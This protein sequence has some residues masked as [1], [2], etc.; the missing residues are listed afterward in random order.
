MAPSTWICRECTLKDDGNKQGPCLICQAPHPKHRA[1]AS[2]PAAAMAPPDNDNA[3]DNN[4]D[5]DDD[6]GD[7]DVDLPRDDNKM[8]LPLPGRL[9]IDIAV[10]SVPAAAAAPLDDN[11]AKDDNNNDDDDNGNDD[12]DFPCDNNKMELSLPGRLVIDIAGIALGD[13]GYKC[14]EHKVCCGQVLN[15]DIVVCLHREEVLVPDDFLGECNMRKETANN[16]FARAVV[17]SKLNSN[18]V[19]TVKGVKVKVAP[20]KGN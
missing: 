16:G 5:D 11:D 18:I 7:D 8:E 4:N 6:N 14:R 20:V 17:I 2:V 3:K 1:V 12:V 9:D 19:C 13:R 10:A 15:V